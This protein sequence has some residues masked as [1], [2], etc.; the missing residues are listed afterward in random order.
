MDG[1]FFL[2]D[3][4]AGFLGDDEVAQKGDGGDADGV[5][6]VATGD[7][8]GAGGC[9]GWFWDGEFREAAA[10]GRA[11]AGWDEGELIGSGRAPQGG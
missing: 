8:D 10:G 6:G 11:D 7:G 4:Q 1:A 3:Y 5:F 9:F 2:I